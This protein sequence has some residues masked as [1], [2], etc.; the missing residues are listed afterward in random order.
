MTHDPWERKTPPEAEEEWAFLW[1]N[2]YRANEGWVIIGPLVAV[3]RNWK[4]WAVAL[5]FFIWINRPDILMA[6]QTIAGGQ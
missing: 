6:L 2:A 5:A 3:V 1:R 4:A